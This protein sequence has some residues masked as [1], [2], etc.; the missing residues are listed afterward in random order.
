VLTTILSGF[1]GQRREPEFHHRR[2]VQKSGRFE[3]TRMGPDH[4]RER[5]A[6]CHGGGESASPRGPSPF[7]RGADLASDYRS[8]LTPLPP[9]EGPGVRI[10]SSSVALAVVSRLR[11]VTHSNP[12]PEYQ[13]LDTLREHRGHRG[14]KER[15]SAPAPNPSFLAW[16][17]RRPFGTDSPPCPPCALRAHPRR[18]RTIAGGFGEA[19]RE[20]ASAA[21]GCG[22]EGAGPE[23]PEG[24]SERGVVA[25]GGP[26]G[27]AN[28]FRVP[29]IPIRLCAPC[30]TRMRFLRGPR[31]FSTS[32]PSLQEAV[33]GLVPLVAAVRLRCALCG[34]IR[35]KPA[36]VPHA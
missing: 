26:K 17:A 10:N 7:G 21:S 3:A 24:G 9:G 5:D 2:G 28:P 15:V 13:F 22:G 16:E 34:E 12:S 29:M 4:P 31:R 19:E 18:R 33:A 20:G 27:K 6:H 11:V 35:G 8:F 30:T 25:G 36:E 23:V 32:P 1:D 14:R